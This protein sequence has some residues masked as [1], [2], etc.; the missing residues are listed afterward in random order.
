[1]RLLCLEMWD[2]FEDSSRFNTLLY[3]NFNWPD[4]QSFSSS[5]KNKEGIFYQIFY[6]P[7]DK[8]KDY[9]KFIVSHNIRIIS[10]NQKA[11]KI[12]KDIR[13]VIHSVKSNDYHVSEYFLKIIYSYWKYN[14]I[15]WSPL[16]H[17]TLLWRIQYRSWHVKQHTTM[18]WLLP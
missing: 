5:T 16:T 13:T 17:D 1:M 6:Q 2:C 14:Y 9:S 8:F 18:D 10:P 7:F 4:K 3:L 11:K 15:F 12:F